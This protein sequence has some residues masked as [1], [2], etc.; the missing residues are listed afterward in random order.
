MSTIHH[1]LSEEKKSV[2]QKAYL[3]LKDG[4]W[5][6]NIDEMK[7]FHP[8]AYLNSLALWRDHVETFYASLTEEHK[9]YQYFKLWRPFYEGWRD[10]TFVDNPPPLESSVDKHESFT[11][12]IA[13]LAEIGFTQVDLFVKYHLWCIIG[14]KKDEQAAK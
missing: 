12:Q 1:L 13:W 5:F 10:R 14:G 9:D 4:G 3:H 8:Q 6:F 7:T 11:D 2:Y